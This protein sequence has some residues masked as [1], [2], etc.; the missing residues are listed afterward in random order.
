MAKRNNLLIELLKDNYFHKFII[1]TDEKCTSFWS[2]WEREDKERTAII[3]E[4]KQILLGFEF[5]ERSIEEKKKSQI[6]EKVVDSIG[7]VEEKSEINARTKIKYLPIAG[8]AAS[9]VLL[10]VSL[11]VFLNKQSSDTTPVNS[12]AAKITKLAPIGKISTFKLID[13]S[14]VRLFSGSKIVFDKE[15]GVS[16]RDIFLEGEAYFDVNKEGEIPFIVN[17]KKLR[18]HSIGT[19]FNVRALHSTGVYDV[20]LVSGKVSVELNQANSNEQTT[21]F[22]SPGEEARLVGSGIRKQN[23]DLNE[24]VAWVDGYIYLNDKTFDESIEILQRWFG[25]EFEVLNNIRDPSITGRGK[26]KNQSLENIL[27][28]LSYSFDFKYTVGDKIEIEFNNYAYE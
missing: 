13:G 15:F 18:T 25:V 24:R 17:T 23:F 6:W 20:S 9:L 2:R 5:D 4:A 3:Q 11:F 21:T 10:I 14:V 8:V 7:Q 19:S 26:F 28:V 12:P 27:H 1:D 16:N 22:L